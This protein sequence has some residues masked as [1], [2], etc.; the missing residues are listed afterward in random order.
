MHP[1][2]MLLQFTWFL[3]CR[4]DSYVCTN[5]KT[6]K[7]QK[8]FGKSVNQLHKRLAK[9]MP[10]EMFESSPEQLERTMKEQG[11]KD[12]SEIMKGFHADV[13]DNCPVPGMCFRCT[14]S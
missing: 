4:Y 13:R 3:S 6:G 8:D 2:A 1:R 12:V 10:K 14:L 7:T 5:G 11:A 9:Q